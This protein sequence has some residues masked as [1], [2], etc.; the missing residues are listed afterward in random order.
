MIKDEKKQAA[1]EY[2]DSLIYS[3]ISEQCDIQNA[4]IA[5]ADWRINAAWHDMSEE[6]KRECMIVLHGNKKTV[7]INWNGDMKWKGMDKFFH[8]EKWAYIEDLLPNME[9]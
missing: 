7:T 9:D 2:E 8:A 1:Q 6:P 4:F 3:S 5:G